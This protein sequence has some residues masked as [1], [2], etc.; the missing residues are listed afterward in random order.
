MG[1]ITGGQSIHIAVG[2]VKVAVFNRLDPRCSDCA[3]NHRLGPNLPPGRRG[4]TASRGPMRLNQPART[5]RRQ[6]LSSRPEHEPGF[7][8]TCSSTRKGSD[9]KTW[10]VEGDPSGS[11]SELGPE[12]S[13]VLFEP[14]SSGPS[15]LNG[16]ETGSIRPT[17]SHARPNR[18][19]DV[20]HPDESR[21]SIAS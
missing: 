10:V 15:H 16:D 14:V 11:E 18:T 17:G 4:P 5:T 20:G 12:T 1:S 9:G 2:D 3:L 6:Y 21:S 19:P 8:R 13:T 7:R